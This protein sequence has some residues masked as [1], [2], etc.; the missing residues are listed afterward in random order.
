MLKNI[1][2]L[3]STGSIGRQTL[4]VIEAFPERFKVCVLVANRSWK[5]L[6]EQTRKFKPQVVAIGDETCYPQLKEALQDLNV[7][8]LAGREGVLEASSYPQADI[9]LSALVG[10]AGLFPTVAALKAGKT[11]AL[12][13]KETL[14]V[15]G[16]IVTKLAQ[17]KGLPLLPVDSEH[18]AIFQCLQGQPRRALKRI[19]LTAS[20]GPFRTTPR[21][22]LAHMRAS[23]ALKH[24]TWSMGAKITIDSSTLMN[25]GFEVLEAM[26]LFQVGMEEI[27]VW[28]HPQS[29]VHSMVEFVDGSVL[30][31]MGLP[32]MRTP[33]QYAL[34]WPERLE[35][36]WETLTLERCSNLTFERPRLDDF[37][38]LRY[39]FEAGKIGG[40]MPCVVNAANEVAVAKFLQDKITFAD[41][42]A[43]IRQC[44]DAHKVIINP[45]LEDLETVDREVRE[46]LTLC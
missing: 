16:E 22:K 7:Q 40:T 20:G 11:I 30:A 19:L 1:S 13:N 39:A 34:G 17:A 37:P 10:V 35:H 4:D 14:V 38:C 9:V 6:A 28:V 43:T 5:L 21:E 29:I 27:E 45:T 15:G 46:K 33:I 42:A 12:A 3:G 8:I 44:M 18:S 26:H 36:S 41:I 23:D 24:P 25:K 31:Q 32:D 2:I